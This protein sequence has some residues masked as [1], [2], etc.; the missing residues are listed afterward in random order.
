MTDSFFKSIFGHLPVATVDDL[1]CQVSRLTLIR[2]VF[3]GWVAHLQ[4]RGLTINTVDFNPSRDMML[5]WVTTNFMQDLGVEVMQL[6][7]LTKF[8]FLLVLEKASDRE[9]IL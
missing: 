6:K 1:G 9:K 2:D 7:V 8:M 5:E 4:E 3:A